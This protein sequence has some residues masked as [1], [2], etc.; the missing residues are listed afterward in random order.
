MHE[1]P[2]LI[3][4]LLVQGSVGLTLFMAFSAGD[5]RALLPA[6]LVACVM[7]GL[8]LIASTLHL[9]YPLNAFNALRHVASSW[10]SRE[11][12]FASLYLAIL[13]MATL[14]VLFKKQPSRVLLALA[15]LAGLVDVYCMGAIYVHSSVA[16]W[17]HFNTWVMFFGAAGILG[18][19]MGNALLPGMTKLLRVAAVLVLAITAIRLLVQ[20][21]YI[22]FLATASLSDVVTFPHQPLVAFH[23]LAGMR[24]CAWALSV[25]ATLLFAIGAWRA[26]RTAVLLGGVGLIVA[27]VLLRFMFF[28]IH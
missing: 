21:E 4:T 15:T 3:F 20:P 27:E 24:I 6:M 26:K 14:L 13:G 17:Q 10:L 22:N 18:A 7:G 8:G 16:T 11:I 9:G 28:S 25:L 2:L 5:R 19:V 1:L 23:Q 12:V